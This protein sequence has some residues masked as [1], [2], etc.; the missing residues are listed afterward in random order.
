MYPGDYVSSEMLLFCVASL[1]QHLPM[2]MCQI[3]PK[4]IHQQVKSQ[5]FGLL[6]CF[7]GT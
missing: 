2:S 3:Y 4:L 1:I 7:L 6:G 5:T